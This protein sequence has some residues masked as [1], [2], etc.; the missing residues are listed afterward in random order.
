MSKV[1]LI[2]NEYDIDMSII[3][4]EQVASHLVGLLRHRKISRSDLAQQLGWSKGRVT[5]VLSGDVNLTIKT[6]TTITE[7]LGYDF[8]IIFHNNNYEKPKQPWQ[9]DR[10]KTTTDQIIIHQSVNNPNLVLELQ[11]GDQ[12]VN[13]VLEGKEKDF[14]VS[15]TPSYQL[16]SESIVN[17]TPQLT[18]DTPSMNITY[19]K[20]N[21][22]GMHHE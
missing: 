20:Q 17:I 3:K 9:I 7:K 21:M 1:S 13:A 22:K 2:G 12:V 6:I 15:V 10:E 16:N 14:Y 19:F 18:L 4:M 5:K 11:T 8:D